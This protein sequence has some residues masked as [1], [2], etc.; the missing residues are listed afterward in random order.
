M[1][2]WVEIWK[3]SDSYLKTKSIPIKPSHH[4]SIPT[5]HYSSL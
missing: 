5:F 4:S 2:Y 3:W 1:E